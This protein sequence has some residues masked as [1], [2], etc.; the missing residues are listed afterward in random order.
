MTVSILVPERRERDVARASVASGDE[1]GAG[2]DG[3]R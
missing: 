3:D 1:W 2:G